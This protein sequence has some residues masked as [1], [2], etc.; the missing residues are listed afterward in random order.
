MD[1]YSAY[2]FKYRKVKM[3]KIIK[4]IYFKYI[5]YVIF[6]RVAALKLYLKNILSQKNI[7]IFKWKISVRLGFVN[8]K[9][10]CVV[11]D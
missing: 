1:T 8:L 6:Y 5:N 7:G 2:I 9:S 11:H 10:A 4:K 3:L